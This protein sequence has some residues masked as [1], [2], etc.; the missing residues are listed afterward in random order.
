MNAEATQDEGRHL[1]LYDGVCGLCNKWVA[2]ILP[3][4][5]KAQFHFASL[6]SALGRSLLSRFGRNPDV[7]DTIYVLV[8][9][10]TESPRILTRSS[11]AL[12]VLARLDSP[13][14]FLK[15]FEVLPTFILD[16]GYSLIARYRYRFFGRYDGC[17]M[18]SAEFA[19]RF[20]DL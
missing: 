5:G 13:W 18:P 10:K 16:A 14:R 7:L 2:Q 6:Q 9:Y 8:D 11:A 3:R 15:I 12:F 20:I 19:S 17:L 1:I 4:D